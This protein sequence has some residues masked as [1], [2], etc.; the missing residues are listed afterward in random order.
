MVQFDGDGNP[1]PDTIIP[2]IDGGTEGFKGQARVIF[3][4]VTTCFECALDAFPPQ[5]NFPLCTIAETPRLPEHCIE[6]A[7]VLQWPENFPEEKMD[8]DNPEHLKWCFEKAAAR[9]SEYGIEGVTYQLTMGVVKRIIPAVASTNAVIAAACAS[10][11]LKVATYCAKAMGDE[12]NYMQFNGTDGLYV[13]SFEYERKEDCLVCSQK[14]QPFS[15]GASDTVG[16]V[17]EKITAD[18][19]LQLK[20]PSV[21][22]GDKTVYMRQ[23]ASVEVA[24]RPNLEKPASEFF[25]QGSTLA[26]TDPTLPHPPYVMLSIN[27]VSFIAPPLPTKRFIPEGLTRM[28]AGAGGVS[29]G[30]PMLGMR[31][32]LSSFVIQ[33][34]WCHTKLLL[35]LWL[36]L[37][38]RLRLRL[39]RHVQLERCAGGDRRL[40]ALERLRLLAVVNQLRA[41]A[42]SQPADLMCAAETVDGQGSCVRGAGYVRRTGVPSSSQSRMPS[43]ASGFF[44]APPTFS[45]T[46]AS[47]S[48]PS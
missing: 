4:M 46:A 1:D 10:E 19:R 31:G 15:I 32:G 44:F 6:W 30:G 34:E 3:P 41:Y 25:G 36:G 33:K 26:V 16:E 35:G 37:C 42:S 20:Q 22:A 40:Q 13:Y 27:V 29:G 8:G 24:T 47:V 12:K 11:A 43:T 45:S 5:V 28:P 14:P 18:P 7:S 9:A 38:F 21:R 2:L 48:A 39:R 23:P 17:L